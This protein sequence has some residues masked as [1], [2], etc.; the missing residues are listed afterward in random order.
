MRIG[1]DFDDTIAD[2]SA[3]LVVQVEQ[4][5]GLDLRALHAEGKP[6]RPI[7]GA[8]VWDA[9]ILEMLET[10]LTLA[11]P[12][13]PEALEVSR[14]LA[15]RHELVVLTSRYDREM[16]YLHAWLERYALPVSSVL[17]TNRGSKAP[18]ATEHSLAVLFDDT[19][20]NFDDFVEHP[21]LPALFVGAG[22]SP[23]A[24]EYG[25]HVRPVNHWQEF[26]VLVRQM[27][28]EGR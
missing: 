3:L 1:L 21:T 17:W 23:R 25:A 15:E 12:P 18:P 24:A 6:G 26:E 28:T 20:R 19:A 9:M 22:M 16:P 8:E 10:D 5:F 2:F 14:R 4:R 11:M 7:A 13:K 27:E